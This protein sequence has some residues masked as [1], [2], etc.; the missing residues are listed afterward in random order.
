MFLSGSAGQVVGTGPP[1][2][3][4]LRA[5]IP[6][7]SPAALRLRHQRPLAWLPGPGAHR[8]DTTFRDAWKLNNHS[9]VVDVACG[10]GRGLSAGF[11][12]ESS[13]K[14][15]KVGTMISISQMKKLGQK[16]QFVQCFTV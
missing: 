12:G 9:S 14:S 16:V 3:S 8:R 5:R 15:W 10:T 11:L 1:W 6:A 13:Y 4:R 7:S 2:E